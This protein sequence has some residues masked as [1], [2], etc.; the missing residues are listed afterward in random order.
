MKGEVK[1]GEVV[2]EWTGPE[3][4]RGGKMRGKG[5]ERKHTRKTLILVPLWFRYPLVA[6]QIIADPE[7]GFR[8]L[9]SEKL[10]ILL[11]GRPCLELIFVSCNFQALALR[12][13]QI[14]GIS[15][16]GIN[17]S[18][19]GSKITGR[20][21]S[22]N[23]IWETVFKI[24]TSSAGRCCPFCQFSASGVKK[25]CALRT[26]NFIHRWRW[27]VKKGNTSQHWRC[28]KSSLP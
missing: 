1:R 14:T 11:W 5:W 20:A 13:G 19:K 27:I 21:L 10:L 3:G 23:I 2:G 28:V 18:K 4:K 22:E 15:L 17:S 9:I 7:K 12:A 16:T 6:Y 24:N 26:L 25:S 8:E